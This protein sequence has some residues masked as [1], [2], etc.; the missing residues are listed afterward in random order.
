MHA[1]YQIASSSDEKPKGRRRSA[2]GQSTDVETRKGES[3]S[4]PVTELS[5]IAKTRRAI[6]IIIIK[7]LS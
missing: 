3:A 6:S 5:K 1:A 2:I 7:G 4:L